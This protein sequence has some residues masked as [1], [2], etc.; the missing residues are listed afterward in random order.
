MQLICCLL[1]NFYLNIFRASLCCVHTGRSPT[2]HNHS[3]HNQ[4]RT[5][6][7]VIH[8]LILLKIGIM[9]PETCWDRSLII[10]TRL[11]ASCWFLFLHPTFMMHGQKS[12]KFHHF[13]SQSTVCCC[14]YDISFS[15][16]TGFVP[17][18]DTVVLIT[19]ILRLE[20]QRKIEPHQE[21]G[22]CRPSVISL[23]NC[24]FCKPVL[25]MCVFLATHSVLQTL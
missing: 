19:R 6:Y 20:E 9:M 11:V 16:N 21:H 24:R 3:Q 7:A 22:T 17:H 13:C 8:S 12:L 14:C 1:S 25:I 5:P 2:P 10:N 23:L 4:C 15:L 18:S